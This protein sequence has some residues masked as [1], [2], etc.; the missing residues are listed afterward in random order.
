MRQN[1]SPKDISWIDDLNGLAEGLKALGHSSR[2]EILYQ[3]AMR[4][5][6]C[7]ADICDCLPLAQSTISQHLDILRKTG[8]IDWQQQGNRSIYTLNPERLA[9]LG[10]ALISLADGQACSKK[11]KSD[12][13]KS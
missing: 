8:L 5:R 9:E 13:L 4:D 11:T 10:E 12:I 7:G 3:L 6:C 1:N 2:L